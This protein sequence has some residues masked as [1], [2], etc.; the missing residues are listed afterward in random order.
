MQNFISALSN[1]NDGFDV[2]VLQLAGQ[3]AQ[4]LLQLRQLTTG[5]LDANIEDLRRVLLDTELRVIWM[6]YW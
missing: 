5:N 4:Q 2:Y 6:Q 1:C 3:I